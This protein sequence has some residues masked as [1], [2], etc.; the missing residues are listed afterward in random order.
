MKEI[1]SKYDTLNIPVFIDRSVDEE[2]ELAQAEWLKVYGAIFGCEDK[3]ETIY[4]ELT[5]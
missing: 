1:L 4:A 2:D 3:A 5:K